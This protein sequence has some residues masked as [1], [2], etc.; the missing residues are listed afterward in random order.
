M[1]AVTVWSW[2]RSS[3]TSRS[4]ARRRRHWRQS[5]NRPASTRAA[6]P[7]SRNREL[8]GS[9]TTSPAQ[10]GVNVARPEPGP[11]GTTSDVP[12]IHPGQDLVE[13]GARYRE[14]LLFRHAIPGFQ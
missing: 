7:V 12:K 10:V 14:S 11:A 8:G 4:A 2:L 9:G 6:M 13:D 3:A 1:V 5:R